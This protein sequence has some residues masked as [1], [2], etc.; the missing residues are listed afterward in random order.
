[1]VDKGSGILTLCES[2]L[3]CKRGG[4][5]LSRKSVV[6]EPTKRREGPAVLMEE[7]VPRVS[8]S[9]LK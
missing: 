3:Q 7:L 6:E 5:S 2:N 4:S 1:M 8:L 9:M